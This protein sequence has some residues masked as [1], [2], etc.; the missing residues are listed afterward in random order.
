MN[1]S[2]LVINRL[3][4][5]NSVYIQFKRIENKSECLKCF[6]RIITAFLTEIINKV[7]HICCQSQPFERRSKATR[8]CG[9]STYESDSQ[10]CC[11]N[12][13]FPVRNGAC[14]AN[15]LFNP[16]N[17]TCCLKRDNGKKVDVAINFLK[18]P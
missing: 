14:C 16:K 10:T 7:S 11:N 4:I 8:C 18:V 5:I 2:S 15:A 9:S 6:S 1:A 13:V 12:V 17:E 3:P